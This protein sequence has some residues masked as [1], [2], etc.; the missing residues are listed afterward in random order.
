MKNTITTRLCKKCNATQKFL[1]L[2]FW[3]K[4][5]LLLFGFAEI[6]AFDTHPPYC[7]GIP[8][9]YIPMMKSIMTKEASSFVDSYLDTINNDYLYQ[10]ITKIDNVA[11]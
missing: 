5:T 4:I 7:P 3:S 10:R 11:L 2:L 1:P 9:K 8:Q 6:L